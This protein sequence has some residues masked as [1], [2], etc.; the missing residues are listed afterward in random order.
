MP[1]LRS[2]DKFV[3]IS[4]G[5]PKGVLP[6]D[7]ELARAVDALMKDVTAA[8]IVAKARYA[9]S[10]GADGSAVG[11]DDIPAKAKAKAKAA[12]RSLGL[13]KPI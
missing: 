13:K 8:K 10:F 7:L 3:E 6:S 12:G 2:H 5:S 9:E 1:E 4:V 11:D